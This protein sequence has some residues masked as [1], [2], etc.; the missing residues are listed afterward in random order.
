MGHD[1]R[2]IERL[3]AFKDQVL[4]QSKEIDDEWISEFLSAWRDASPTVSIFWK[5]D[6]CWC[7]DSEICGRT[8]CFR[9]LS[10][11]SPETTVFTCG[12][13]MDT[14]QCPRAFEGEDCT[15]EF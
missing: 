13:L 3:K 11:K 8:D 7:M 6:I 9:H 1:E 2:E 12:N 10:H 4:I 5:D 15:E 14:D